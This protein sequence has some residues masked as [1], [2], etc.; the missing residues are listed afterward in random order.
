MADKPDFDPDKTA[1]V[2]PRQVPRKA[3]TTETQRGMPV[4]GGPDDPIDTEAS[5]RK[6]AAIPVVPDSGVREEKEGQP[7]VPRVDPVP[8]RPRVSDSGNSRYGL[9]HLVYS[10]L[11]GG[12]IVAT[13][14]IGARGCVSNYVCGSPIEKA[15]AAATEE[16][17]TKINTLEATSTDNLALAERRCKTRIDAAV[18]AFGP[19]PDGD[20]YS[21]LEQELEDCNSNLTA[22]RSAK[23]DDGLQSRLGTCHEAYRTLEKTHKELQKNYEKLQGEYAS[24]EGKDTSQLENELTQCVDLRT[25][26]GNNFTQYLFFINDLM[27]KCPKLFRECGAAAALAE[28]TRVLGEGLKQDG[29]NVPDEAMQKLY[30]PGDGSPI[31]P[32]APLPT[33]PN[34]TGV[35]T[36][37]SGKPY[38]R[39]VI[40]PIRD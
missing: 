38:L 7:Y 14:L 28:Q 39:M 21:A 31:V 35:R 36:T 11:V 5:R 23:T 6:V 17:L 12:A 24:L 15:V 10:A 20:K 37:G 33:G 2:R 13:A 8:T 1:V 29:Y 16:C 32:T 22:A 40:E 30:C 34:V 19:D 4:A 18:A 3:T 9:R 25:K 26:L 27:D